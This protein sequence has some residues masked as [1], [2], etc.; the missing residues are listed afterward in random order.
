MRK[1]LTALLLVTAFTMSAFSQDDG[2]PD[3]VR[4]ELYRVRNVSADTL[5]NAMSIAFPPEDGIVIRQISD[6][7]SLL[8]RCPSKK[9]IAVSRLLSEI[10]RTPTQ[11]SIQFMIIDL[12]GEQARELSES[13][14]RPDSNRLGEKVMQWVSK[15]TGVISKRQQNVQVRERTS[16]E[17]NSDQHANWQVDGD[18]FGTSDGASISV[19][20]SLAEGNRIDLKL[21]VAARLPA[22]NAKAPVVGKDG[23]LP[24]ITVVEGRRIEL[25]TSLQVRDSAPTMI[26]CSAGEADGKPHATVILVT[27]ALDD[28]KRDATRTAGF[29]PA[30]GRK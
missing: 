7:N 24:Q 18:A 9:F 29:T 12:E 1:S 5:E 16:A 3:N 19:E 23:T 20:P 25:Q 30:D 17:I 15:G 13:A 2:K 6:T 11:F 8:I 27:A 28:A 26:S 4:V 10:D 21:T 22:R 14:L